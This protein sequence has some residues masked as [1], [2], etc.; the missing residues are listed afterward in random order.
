M[1]LDSFVAGRYAQVY[2]GVDTGITENG[3]RIDIITHAQYIN[4]SDAYGD[5]V[6][7]TIYRG[8]DCLISSEGLAFK[9]GSFHPF[10][11]FGGTTT[12]GAWGVLRNPG[13]GAC[14]V[15]VLGSDYAKTLVLVAAPGTPAAEASVP[16]VD[17]ITAPKTL[18]EPGSKSLLLT[19]ELRKVPLLLRAYPV[20]TDANVDTSPIVWFIYA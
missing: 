13:V 10:N 18:L 16:P 2:D 5:S 3:I 8:G 20:Q 1:A 17:S 11:P 14:E 15:G 4:R 7:D 19:T 9:P 12:A 6:L